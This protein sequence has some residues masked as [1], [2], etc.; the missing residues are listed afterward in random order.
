M[1]QSSNNAAELKFDGLAINLRYEEG[2]LVQAATRG[3]G[4][5]GEDVTHNIRTIPG[6]PLRLQG[7]SA[8]RAGSEGARCICVGTILSVLMLASVISAR[9]RLSIRVIPLLVQCANWTRLLRVSAPCRF[10]AYGI[11]EVIGWD[12][13]PATHSALVDA[14]AAFGLPVCE[15]RCVAQGAQ[16]LVVFHQ[17]IAAL[18]NSLPFDIDGIVYKVNSLVLQRELGFRN[19]EPHWAVAHKYPAQ[20]EITQLLDIEVQV[21]RTGAIT[22]VARLAPVFVGGVTVTNATLH[23]EDEVLRKGVMIGDWVIVRRAG[24]VIPEVVEPVMERRPR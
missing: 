12:A 3:D 24:D 8:P 14:L 18:R 2:V 6:I 20:E 13:P 5:T 11:G 7:N 23:N 10:F 21:G 1:L 19:R 22:P 16:D 4:E 9:K 17:R 15:H